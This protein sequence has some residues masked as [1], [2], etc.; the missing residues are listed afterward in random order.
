MYEDF[1]K[2]CEPLNKINPEIPFTLNLRKEK[3][4]PRPKIAGG[5][6]HAHFAMNGVP[7]LS[8]GS[9]DP[10]GSGFSY[11]EIWH[12]ERDSYN[13]SIPEYMEYTSVVMAVVLYNLAGLDHLLSREG[14]YDFDVR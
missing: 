9:G 12:T 8:F 4:Q 14:L 13:M 11:Y 7:T 10:K 3:P 2:V 1:K 5:S 6:D